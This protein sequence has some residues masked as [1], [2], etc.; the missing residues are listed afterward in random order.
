VPVHGWLFLACHP[1]SAPS[2]A[3]D[4]VVPGIGGH[5]DPV[6]DQQAIR[7]RSKPPRTFVRGLLSARLAQQDKPPIVNSDKAASAAHAQLMRTHGV[8]NGPD[9]TFPGTGDDLRVAVVLPAIRF[10]RSL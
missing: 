10:L 6:R 3:A 5:R 1:A 2:V 4:L 7:P 9:P 8:L